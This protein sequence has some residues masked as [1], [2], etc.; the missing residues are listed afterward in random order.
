[1][2]GNAVEFQICVHGKPCQEY[3]QHNKVY[4]EGRKGSDFTLRLRNRERRRVLAVVSIDGKDITTGKLASINGD[5]YVLNPYETYN[6]PGWLLDNHSVAK[7][8]FS[9]DSQ[10]YAAKTGDTYN[11]GLIGCAVFLEK[12]KTIRRDVTLRSAGSRGMNLGEVDRGSSMKGTVCST[13]M[14]SEIGTGFGKKQDFNTTEVNF[15]K[16]SNTPYEVLEI[17]YDT[18]A[19]LKKRGVDL[20]ESRVV[21]KEPSA[22]PADNNYCTPPEG[23]EG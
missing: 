23:W 13:A 16:A 12:I 14:P 10:S 1:M 22:F 17:I 6:I 2:F 3:Y 19:G 7:F 4:I 18:R 8:F 15:V 11:I 5:G 20:S 9:K 21:V